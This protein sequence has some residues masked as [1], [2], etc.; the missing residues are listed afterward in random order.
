MQQFADSALPSPL[1]FTL[2]ATTLLAPIVLVVIV[3]AW[4]IANEN[5]V[6]SIK[7]E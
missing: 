4:H 3:R 5:P 1:W 2:A 6:D 7:S